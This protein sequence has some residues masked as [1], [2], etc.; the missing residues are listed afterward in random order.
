MATIQVTLPDGKGGE[1]FGS[2]EAFVGGD[3]GQ[4]EDPGRGGQKPVYWVSVRELN[5]ACLQG[6]FVCGRC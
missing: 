1:A 5:F 4:L 2:N 6:N 3:Q